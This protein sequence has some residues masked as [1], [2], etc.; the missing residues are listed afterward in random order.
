MKKTTE[1]KRSQSKLRRMRI[2]RG[3]RQ[4]D[5]SKAS[6]VTQATIS[7]LECT[8]VLKRADKAMAL[9]QALKCTIEDIY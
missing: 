8:G 2:L 7:R 6:G 4:I 9:A 5:L 1:K 3:M